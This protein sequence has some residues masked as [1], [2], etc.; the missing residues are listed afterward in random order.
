M[1]QMGQSDREELRKTEV[2]EER[3]KRG[4]TRRTNPSSS[5]IP[6]REVLPMLP[7]GSMWS[8]S[9]PNAPG[10]PGSLGPHQSSAG[11]VAND[12]IVGSSW[13]PSRR[14]VIETAAGWDSPGTSC[15]V[16][17]GAIYIGTLGT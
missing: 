9:T 2:E 6:F 3:N 8:G 14:L 4:H 5:T 13:L 12:S 1:G 16:D 7:C 17:V 11:R 15:C 10:L